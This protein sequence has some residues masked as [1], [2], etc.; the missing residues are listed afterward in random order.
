MGDAHARARLLP[1][2]P[3]PLVEVIAA[4]RAPWSKHREGGLGSRTR[5]SS[6][7]RRRNVSRPAPR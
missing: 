7:A 1:H 4:S 2:P 6:D 5:K 3:P